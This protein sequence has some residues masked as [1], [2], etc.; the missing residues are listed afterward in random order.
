MQA[1]RADEVKTILRCKDPVALTRSLATSL[2]T[3]EEN[4][5]SVAEGYACGCEDLRQTLLDILHDNPVLT[6]T[7]LQ[8]SERAWTLLVNLAGGKSSCILPH[9]LLGH[10]ETALLQLLLLTRG[11]FANKKY[12]QGCT[13]IFYRDFKYNSVLAE[14]FTRARRLRILQRML[15]KVLKVP[16]AY[17]HV[18]EC[19][20]V[21]ARDL[22]PAEKAM[23]DLAFEVG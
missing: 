6:V 4:L 16:G 19:L 3:G 13:E 1:A 20:A 21:L 12:N 17:L 23:L 7:A 15:K 8:T 14:E 11:V 2:L 18:R 5:D 10:A 22:S 9:A